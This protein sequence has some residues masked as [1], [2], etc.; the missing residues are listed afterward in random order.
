MECHPLGSSTNG[1]WVV[2]FFCHVF[3]GA[4]HA[5][6]FLLQE[7]VGC[8]SLTREEAKNN[9]GRFSKFYTNQLFRGTKPVIIANCPNRI[10]ETRTV[11]M[12]WQTSRRTINNCREKMAVP[13]FKIFRSI[14]FHSN[15]GYIASCFNT[16]RKINGRHPNK[17]TTRILQNCML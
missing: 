12:I 6:V 4:P 1:I 3:L 16:L 14:P 13:K 5:V 10:L 17:G 15:L 7:M 2:Q 9:Q 11:W 8:Y